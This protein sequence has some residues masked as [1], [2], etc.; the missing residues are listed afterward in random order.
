MWVTPGGTHSQMKAWRSMTRWI[1]LGSHRFFILLQLCLLSFQ[2]I[3]RENVK[4]DR[5]WP[6]SWQGTHGCVGTCSFSWVDYLLPADE[7]ISP[8]GPDLLLL[9]MSEKYSWKF[10][11]S[12]TLECSWQVRNW[13]WHHVL[14]NMCTNFFTLH[15]GYPFREHN[16]RAVLFSSI[17][18]RVGEMTHSI[19]HV[20][21]CRGLRCVV[22]TGDR[23]VWRQV[24]KVR[25]GGRWFIRC[26]VRQARRLPHTLLCL[27]PH[28]FSF[29]AL[30]TASTLFV[31]LNLVYQ[32][33]EHV[34]LTTA[35]CLYYYS[36]SN[37][38][39]SAGNSMTI[40]LNK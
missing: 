27:Y 35:F 38:E 33:L 31:Y 17:Q 19:N 13:S 39:N 12:R 4:E 15:W 5:W 7:H 3:L 22:T 28:L 36:I 16:W 2:T 26:W 10:C 37:I 40:F 21:G 30:T 9:S 25:Y 6:S 18:C 29:T 34:F 14:P 20:R 1:R 32:P 8:L 11:F 23:D 24:L